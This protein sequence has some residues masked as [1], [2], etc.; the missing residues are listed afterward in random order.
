MKKLFLGL[1]F[2]P[3]I[4]FSQSDLVKALNAMTNHV[5]GTNELTDSQLTEYFTDIKT[6]FSDNFSSVREHVLNYT[7]AYESKYEPLFLDGDNNLN[8]INIDDLKIESQTIFY[9][10]QTIFDNEYSSLKVENMSGIKFEAHEGF[11]GKISSSVPRIETASIEINGDYSY[12]P[13]ARR[14]G[15]TW[16]VIRPT[17]YYA[18]ASEIITIEIPNNLIN[19]GIRVMIG[20][21]QT[22]LYPRRNSINRFYRI[23]K[24]FN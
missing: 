16:P 24:R 3:L 14:L 13:G 12:I 1:L 18:A 20:A 15:D 10:Q 21:H 4:S 8:K 22:D 11:P 2:I 7:N 5:N 19:K 17:G 23:S 6:N 9:L